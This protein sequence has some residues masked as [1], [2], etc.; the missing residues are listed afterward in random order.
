MRKGT[1]FGDGGD[2]FIPSRVAVA[3]R[4]LGVSPERARDMVLNGTAYREGGE[5]TPHHVEDHQYR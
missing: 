3:A 1:P 4:C 2:G 5:V